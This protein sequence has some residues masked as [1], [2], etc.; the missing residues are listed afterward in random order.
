MLLPDGSLIGIL[1]SQPPQV[2]TIACKW[3]GPLQHYPYFWQVEDGGFVD[4]PQTLFSRAAAL[5]MEKWLLRLTLAQREQFTELLF[6]ILQSTQAQT[7]N[8]LVRGWFSNT[9]PSPAPSFRAWICPTSACARTC[10]FH[11]GARW[12][13]AREFCF[14][15]PKS[16]EYRGNA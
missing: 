16:L 5:T 8:D 6:D 15:D 10:C 11:S 1:F 14:P 13:K 4:S 12:P 2:R 3:M 9:L 7:L